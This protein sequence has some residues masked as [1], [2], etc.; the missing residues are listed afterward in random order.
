MPKKIAINL[1]TAALIGFIPDE[2]LMSL[3]SRTFTTI[4]EQSD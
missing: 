2:S 1:K 4:A 3:V